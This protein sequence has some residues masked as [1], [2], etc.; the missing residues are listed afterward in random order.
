MEQKK[1][2][3]RYLVLAIIW[4]VATAAVTAGMIAARTIAALPALLFGLCAV[5]AV[6][7]WGSYLREKKLEKK[8]NG[9]KSTSK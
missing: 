7:W 2:V 8:Q 1:A 4:T 3:K 6:C 5:C 9:P